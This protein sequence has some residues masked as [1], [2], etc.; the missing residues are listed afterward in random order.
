M[1]LLHCA[2]IAKGRLLFPRLFNKKVGFFPTFS[3]VKNFFHNTRLK[4]SK[5][6][7]IF[8]LYSLNPLTNDR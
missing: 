3:F 5:I 6:S 1:E 8:A 2:I 4:F 7:S